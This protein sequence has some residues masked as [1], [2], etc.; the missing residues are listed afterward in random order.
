MHEPTVIDILQ[1][2]STGSTGHF[3][4]G[5]VTLNW[6]PRAIECHWRDTTGVP[7]KAS[8]TEANQL[9]IQVARRIEERQPGMLGTLMG[10]KP[11]QIHWLCANLRS[12]DGLE[13]PIQTR[14]DSAERLEGLPYMDLRGP[15][16]PMDQWL[17][18]VNTTRSMGADIAGWNEMLAQ[19]PPPPTT[20]RRVLVYSTK[21]PNDGILRQALIAANI[22]VEIHDGIGGSASGV[23]YV[24]R[25]I[26]VAPR[27]AD[28]AHG[29]I[30]DG[31]REGWLAKITE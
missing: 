7:L 23:T 31:V 8:I 4:D 2:E 1:Q 3:D 10:R 28:K 17:A 21:P 12:R 20:V 24:V 30:Q 16:L 27:D 19:Q 18:I 13:L 22:P 26:F 15:T 29:I 5:S 6:S 14:I 11:R 25:N 9:P